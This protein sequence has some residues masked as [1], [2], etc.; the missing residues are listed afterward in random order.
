MRLRAGAVQRPAGARAEGQTVALEAEKS[1][2]QSLVVDAE[3]A[4]QSGAGQRF[5]GIGKAFA[6][7][8]D[9]RRGR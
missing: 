8:V 1:V 7:E 3:L 4:S 6:D 2:S 9:Q 5:G